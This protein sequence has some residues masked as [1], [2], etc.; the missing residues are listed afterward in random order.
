MIKRYI[1]LNCLHLTTSVIVDKLIFV[2]EF[3]GGRMS[4]ERLNG[5]FT[6]DNTTL[7]K[8]IESD[9]NYGVEFTLYKTNVEKKVKN[10]P[11]RE[12]NNYSN[13]ESVNNRQKAVEWIASKLNIE[14]P[15]TMI[16]INIKHVAQERGFVFENWV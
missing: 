5:T 6:T 12:K 13:I 2:I 16:S 3:K 4:P 8:A 15:K 10:K 9:S 7:Q 1:S 14:I 11:K